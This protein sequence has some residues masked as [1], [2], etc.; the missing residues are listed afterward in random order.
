MKDEFKKLMLKEA[1]TDNP[2]FDRRTRSHNQMIGNSTFEQDDQ[3]NDVTA[4]L[5]KRK[6]GPIEQNDP[7]FNVTLPENAVVVTPQRGAPKKTILFYRSENKNL[8]RKIKRLEEQLK[9]AQAKP[10]DLSTSEQIKKLI[11]NG[12]FK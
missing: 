7:G 5:M 11:R 10:S 2:V 9:I 3:R 4:T 12:D 8:K 6:K 1:E